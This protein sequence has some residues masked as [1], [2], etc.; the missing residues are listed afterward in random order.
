MQTSKIALPEE[1][2]KHLGF[3]EMIVNVGP[4]SDTEKLDNAVHAVMAEGCSYLSRSDRSNFC[5]HKHCLSIFATSR[6][7]REL[8]QIAEAWVTDRFQFSI[9]ESQLKAAE[10]NCAMVVVEEGL[11]VQ[12]LVVLLNQVRDNSSSIKEGIGNIPASQLWAA[13]HRLTGV[14]ASQARS[15][16]LIF[17]ALCTHCSTTLSLFGD[18]PR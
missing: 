3:I 8:T 9:A 16:S 11:T 2:K 1:Q 17:R 12:Q 6:V 5:K 14:I 7:G 4:D 15:I 10:S 13:K 18:G